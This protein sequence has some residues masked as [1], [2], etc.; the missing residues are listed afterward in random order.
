ELEAAAGG[1]CH[2][3]RGD[4]R[5]AVGAIVIGGQRAGRDEALDRVEEPEQLVGLVE[6]RR[7]IAELA[8]DLRETARAEP[9]AAEVDQ[10]QLAIAAGE[11]GRD[12]A[13]NVGA[14]A[15]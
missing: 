1:E 10:E 14:R 9:A 2:L 4:D 12:G 7:H 11:L 3:E 13:A 5:A 15:E 8:E 6:I